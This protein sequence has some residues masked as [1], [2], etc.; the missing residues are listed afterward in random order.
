MSVVLFQENDSR[1]GELFFQ[2]EK[3]QGGYIMI[4]ATYRIKQR[5]SR[6]IIPRYWDEA[7]VVNLIST[8]ERQKSALGKI[9]K[10]EE[11]VMSIMTYSRPS[12]AECLAAE[13]LSVY[14]CRKSESQNFARNSVH[15]WL[16]QRAGYVWYLEL[17]E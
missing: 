17:T 8:S 5:F 15:G 6:K 11:I 7:P 9:R 3:F 16:T 12:I 1:F 4:T 14:V 2:G 13:R 10:D